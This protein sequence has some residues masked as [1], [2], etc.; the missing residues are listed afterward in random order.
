MTPPTVR[1]WL[2]LPRLAAVAGRTLLACALAWAAPAALAAPASGSIIGNQAAATYTDASGNS[3]SATSNLV[4]TVVQQVGALA[5]TG[6]T[7]R[8]AA[9]GG[10]AYF[11]HTL[12]NNG[13]GADTF[14]LALSHGAGTGG[15]ALTDGNV[16]IY[17][18]AD[19][20]GLPDTT[21]PLASGTTAFTTPAIAAGGTYRFVVALTVPGTAT[22]GQTDNVT[23]TA[24]PVTDSIYTPTTTT[25]TNTATV[26]VATITP[27]FVVSKSISLSQGGTSASNCTTNFTVGTCVVV[28]YTLSYTNAGTAAGHLY[29]R[30]AIGGTGTAT[31]GMQYVTGSARWNGNSTA[32]TDAAGAETLTGIAYQAVA[33]G[34]TTTL[35]AVIADVQPGSSGTLRFD[36]GVLSTAAA[37]TASTTNTAD[38]GTAS[39]TA[40]PGTAPSTQPTNAASYS[41]NAT[42]GVSTN[43]STTNPALGTGESDTTN[44][45]LI[46]WD[47]AAVAGSTLTFGAPGTANNIVVWNTGTVS[48]TFNVRIEEQTTPFPAG[49]VITLYRADGVTPLADTNGD[50][51]VDTGPLAAGAYLPIV[52]KVVLP[53]SA[54]I[55]D[56]C[57]ASSTVKTV[58]VIATSVGSSTTTNKA[59]VRLNAGRLVAPTVSLVSGSADTGPTWSSGAA[60]AT[61]TVS[62]GSSTSFEMVVRNTAASGAPSAT[63]EL[64]YGSA[65]FTAPTSGNQSTAVA[66][67]ASVP[68]TGWTVT[69]RS[70][71]CASNGTVITSTASIAAGNFVN[72][73]AVVTTT[74][75]SP[76]ATSSIYFRAISANNYSWSTMR[77]AVTVTAVQGLSLMANA[78]GQLVAGGSVQYAHTLTNTG[79]VSCSVTGYTVSQT[80]SGQGWTAVVYKD[81]NGNGQVDGAE[82]LAG[83]ETLTGGASIQLLVRVFAPGGAAIGAADVLTLSVTATC[84]S[85]AVSPAPS[86]ID[87]TTVMSGQLRLVKTQL[88]DAACTNNAPSGFG[89]AQVSAAPGQCVVYQVVA[90]NLGASNITSVV[91]SDA[92]PTYT[93]LRG[94]TVPTCSTGTAAPSVGSTSYSG[95]VSCTLSSPLLPGNSVTLVF[96]VRI[97]P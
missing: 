3:Q 31:A 65:D 89:L 61:N 15:L 95:P 83:A 55:T 79:N 35:Q 39:T 68:V 22:V 47:S 84:N 7:A 88:L 11:A 67:P 46:A 29:L 77:N 5:L 8:S 81:S 60:I 34:S 76:A 30:D 69:F 36:V 51:V 85:V 19:G 13:N 43:T 45:N 97:D 52:V 73:C 9:P 59:Y 78:S 56:V 57:G 82:T 66:N 87:R 44:D 6:T 49:R 86:V 72:V 53:A 10:T 33:S 91:I 40:V 74:A 92:T 42:Y 38:F 50:G 12:T 28:S 75:A 41:V 26:T 17:L 58:H 2:A 48:D 70:G 24:N 20:N 90:T 37:G 21:T 32:L 62:G 71:T 18:D 4:Q 64:Q 1:R 96:H 25:A 94:T 16:A 27:V 93:T 14:S 63:Y 54:C 80:L 23:V